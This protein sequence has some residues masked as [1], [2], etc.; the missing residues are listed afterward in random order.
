MTYRDALKL[1]NGD[2]VTIKKTGCVML[3]VST[4]TQLGRKNVNI[5]CENGNWYTHTEVK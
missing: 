1:H 2:E 3:V 4:E 5:M